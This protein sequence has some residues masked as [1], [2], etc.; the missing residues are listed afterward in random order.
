[1]YTAAI[2]TALALF[3]D[4]T[5]YAILPSEYPAVGLTVVQVGWLLSVNRFARLPL[6]LPSG[7]VTDRFGHKRPFIVGL[8][9][10]ALS[11]LGYGLFKSFAV[12]LLMRALWGLAWAL[13]IV[14]AY[15]IILDVSSQ[16]TRAQH[17]AMFVSYSYFGGALGSML[18]GF[19]VDRVG[20][21]AAMIV[22]GCCTCLACLLALTV[23]DSSD[24]HGL[25]TLE[26]RPVDGRPAPSLPWRTLDARLWLIVALNLMHRFLFAG[27]FFS[28]FALYLRTTL[29]SQVS[30]GTVVLGVASLSGILLFVREGLVAAV[31]PQFGRWSDRIG[32][33]RIALLL[34]ETLGVLGL[35]GLARGSEL[36]WIGG[37]FVA[38]AVAYGLVPSILVAWMGDLVAPDR[39]A[40]LVGVYQTAGDLGSGLGPPLA[41]ALVGR[42]GVQR[43][44]VA[45]AVTLVTV[46]IVALRI[47]G[48][49]NAPQ[50]R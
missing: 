14:A 24:H 20:L 30:V 6:N 31:V 35:A 33:R 41:Y 13:L 8:A 7:W 49:Q 5:M 11:T 47:M 15:K 4:Q 37:A 36:W 43:V 26:T 19:L 27:V 21:S 45:A 40:T 28:T 34:G 2:C 3:G 39:R 10:G 25:P 29:G 46:V 22:L 50:R 23:P 9:I 17:S 16:E 44:Y 18:G 48:R 12:L 1:M 42:I 32:D 38:L